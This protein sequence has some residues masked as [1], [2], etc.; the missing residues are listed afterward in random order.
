MFR[1]SD[2]I[3]QVLQLRIQHETVVTNN[4]R[5]LSEGIIIIII[6]SDKFVNDLLLI[7]E[8]RLGGA[9]REGE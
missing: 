3:R 1:S 4:L 7:L 2:L 8:T 9:G 5:N 6:T